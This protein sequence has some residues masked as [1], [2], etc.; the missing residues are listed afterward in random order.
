MTNEDCSATKS[1]RELLRE[2]AHEVRTPLNAMMG[3]STLLADG[4]GG[5][6]LTQ[7]Q[8]VDYGKI[9][10]GATRRLL[11]ICE[12]VLDE[13]MVGHAVIRKENINF[14]SFC[15]E[16][17]HTFEIDAAEKGV[18]LN[19]K[20]VDAFP[21][22]YTDPVILFEI[23]SNLVN[24]AIKFTPRGG[25]ITIKGE[26]DNQNNGLILV[27]QD[28]G[29]GIPATILMS[30]IKGEKATISYAHSDR[31]GWGLGISIVKEKTGLLGGTFE[32]GSA[33]GGGTV[34]CVRLPTE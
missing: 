28:T 32:I 29:K 4:L 7:E 12:R 30:L 3:F 33:P 26:V 1:D 18:T 16:I 10:N 34:V 20:I 24:N 19:Y 11:Q 8:S 22:L 14:H 2:F 27:V 13:A 17:V 5:K 21:C 9:I 25:I 15:A 6:P 31:K 23:L